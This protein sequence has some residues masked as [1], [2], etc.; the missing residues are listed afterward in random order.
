MTENYS[1]REKRL[2]LSLAHSI[3][4]NSPSP[5]LLQNNRAVEQQIVPADETVASRSSL[6]ISS[7]CNLLSFVVSLLDSSHRVGRYS[8]CK[9][10]ANAKSLF[11][12]RLLAKQSKVKAKANINMSIWKLTQLLYRAKATWRILRAAP[13]LSPA[14]FLIIK[15]MYDNYYESTGGEEEEEE[16]EYAKSERKKE[17]V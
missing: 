17:R 12:V 14:P 11:S 7:L 2:A 9:Y 15:S 10:H 1:A 13:P 8:L 5:L 4:Y 3:R 6:K 16:D